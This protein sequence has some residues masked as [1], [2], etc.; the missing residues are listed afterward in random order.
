VI[1]AKTITYA[2]VLA[3]SACLCIS[4]KKAAGKGGTC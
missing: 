3:G 1:A 2:T 4:R